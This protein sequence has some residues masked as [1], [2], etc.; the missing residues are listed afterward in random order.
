MCSTGRSW[1]KYLEEVD[2]VNKVYKV[3]EVAVNFGII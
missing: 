2:R 1:R 3:D